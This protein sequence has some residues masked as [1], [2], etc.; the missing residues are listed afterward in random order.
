[1]NIIYHIYIIFSNI[2]IPYQ[3]ISGTKQKSKK[4]TILAYNKQASEI[5]AL[6]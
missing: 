3:K 1:M 4:I 6:F 2:F 5:Y